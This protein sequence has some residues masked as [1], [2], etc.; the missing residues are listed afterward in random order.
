M[1]G[2]C[3]DNVAYADSVIT[4]TA[5][6]SMHLLVCSYQSIKDRCDLTYST[7]KA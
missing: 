5:V 3:P 4:D 7:K 2:G 6:C 1:L